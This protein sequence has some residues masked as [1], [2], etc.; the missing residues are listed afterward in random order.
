MTAAIIEDSLPV[1]ELLQH[2]LRESF[3]DMKIAGIAD[4]LP[5][6]VELIREVRPDLLFLDIQIKQGTSFSLLNTLESQRLLNAHLIFVTGHGSKE[7]VQRAMRYAALDFIEKPINPDELRSAVERACRKDQDQQ[8]I[9]EKLG[10]MMELLER[11]G[12]RLR[13]VMSVPLLHGDME[14]VHKGKVVYIESKGPATIVHLE[15]GQRLASSQ[16]LKYYEHLLSGEGGFH[17]ISPT[18]LVN[19]LHIQRY[20][21]GEKYLILR[22]GEQLQA[23]RRRGADFYRDVSGALT[24]DRPS[25]KRLIDKIQHMLRR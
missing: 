10:L 11:R 19:E 23:S 20:T 5:D 22:N 17:R 24:S 12:Q 13:P 25:L 18:H 9:I 14:I 3:P 2:H 4:C 21:S 8:A 6:A 7:N 15:D 16:N 1:A